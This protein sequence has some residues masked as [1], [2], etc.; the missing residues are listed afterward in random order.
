MHGRKEALRRQGEHAPGQVLQRTSDWEGA[1]E[2]RACLPHW[3][4]SLSAHSSAPAVPV[5][6]GPSHGAHPQVARMT[7]GENKLFFLKKDWQTLHPP[8]QITARLFNLV[9]I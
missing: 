7:Q 8:P 6:L 3:C 4:T 5:L 2:T 9:D 1:A